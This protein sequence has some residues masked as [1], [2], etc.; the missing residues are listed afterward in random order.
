[1]RATFARKRRFDLVDPLLRLLRFPEPSAASVSVKTAR[2]QQR[3][4]ARLITGRAPGS[5]DKYEVLEHARRRAQM[6]ARRSLGID[7]RG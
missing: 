7:G 5:P 4:E 2:P 1:V 3:P 6:A